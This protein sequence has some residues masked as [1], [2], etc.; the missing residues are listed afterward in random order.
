M[1]QMKNKNE[2]RDG[3]KLYIDKI[4]KC[5]CAEH[6]GDQYQLSCKIIQRGESIYT[7]TM[8]GE[9]IEK[10]DKKKLWLLENS[11]ATVSEA[12]QKFQE[13]LLRIRQIPGKQISLC[14][15]SI[16]VLYEHLS[17]DQFHFLIRKKL[18]DGSLKEA[19]HENSSVRN[20]I[21]R[22]R[23]ELEPE[24]KSLY[25]ILMDSSGEKINDNPLYIAASENKDEDL[26]YRLKLYYNSATDSDCLW[27]SER[28]GTHILP[29]LPEKYDRIYVVDRNS[30]RES[31]FALL[32]NSG[33]QFWHRPYFAMPRSTHAKIELNPHTKYAVDA[34]K[35]DADTITF[36]EY[37]ELFA[38]EGEK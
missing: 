24:Y 10:G 32:H 3:D 36:Q 13:T 18:P 31:D 6:T 17:W 19:Y 22:I 2:Y 15:G 35:V 26:K 14:D 7:Y 4:K 12:I 33:Y 29:K 21:F 28:L 8:G 1:E 16:S 34:A 5:T 20:M 9:F 25:D 38:A 11:K 23:D 27:I 37:L 30:I